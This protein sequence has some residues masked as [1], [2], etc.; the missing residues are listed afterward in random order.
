MSESATLF[1]NEKGKKKKAPKLCD[2]ILQYAKEE[3]FYLEI[4]LHS[5]DRLVARLIDFDEDLLLLSIN[6]KELYCFKNKIAY[7][8]LD[9]QKKRNAFQSACQEESKEYA[10]SSN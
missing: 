4:F 8:C 2:K 5:N 7:F 10:F 9:N 6:Q 1:Q 3:N